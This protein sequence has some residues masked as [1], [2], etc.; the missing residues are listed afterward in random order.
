[1]IARSQQLAGAG[2][3]HHS[4]CVGWDCQATTNMAPRGPGGGGDG[5][6]DDSSVADV[7]KWLRAQGFSE[8]VRDILCDF[9]GKRLLAL[10]LKTFKETLGKLD[11][12]S[13][14]HLLHSGV[15]APVWVDSA[16]CHGCGAPFSF[17]RRKHHCRNCG[18]IVCNTCSSKRLPLPELGIK[19]KVRVCGKCHDLLV[20]GKPIKTEDSSDDEADSLPPD[21]EDLRLAIALLDQDIAAATSTPSGQWDPSMVQGRDPFRLKS[22]SRRF[23]WSVD[24]PRALLA[25]GNR[26][27]FQAPTAV[28]ESA[29]AA[30]ADDGGDEAIYVDVSTL[31]PQDEENIYL[32]VLPKTAVVGATECSHKALPVT[33]SFAHQCTQEIWTGEPC[34]LPDSADHTLTLSAEELG[35]ANQAWTMFFEAFEPYADAMDGERLGGILLTVLSLE[36]WSEDQVALITALCN[37]FV[38][39]AGV[40][41]KNGGDTPRPKLFP[42]ATPTDDGTSVDIPFHTHNAD[43]CAVAPVIVDT[44][45]DGRGLVGFADEVLC[46]CDEA[47]NL[48]TTSLSEEQI[49]ERLD[50][51][52]R[53]AGVA[54]S[55]HPLVFTIALRSSVS[56]EEVLERAI[57][58]A[59][60]A[61]EHFAVPKLS[62]PLQV[63]MGLNAADEVEKGTGV[64]VWFLDDQKVRITPMVC[65]QLIMDSVDGAGSFSAPVRIDKAPEL[66]AQ[67]VTRINKACGSVM[68]Q[69]VTLPDALLKGVCLRGPTATKDAALSFQS[70]LAKQLPK[71]LRS[72]V[73]VH[74]QDPK[75]TFAGASALTRLAS[76]DTMTVS[77]RDYLQFGS[78][79]IHSALSLTPMPVEGET[80]R[81]ISMCAVD[82]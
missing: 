34:P 42:E 64:D 8:T 11:G 44:G 77:R 76:F 53:E 71:A 58:I 31:I 18:Q 15:K 78:S 61:F 29:S 33:D 27:S 51:L 13:C 82:G 47:E 40:W 67:F 63:A 79:V 3:E 65:G 52:C 59:T 9:N 50:R 30:G 25:A 43:A 37:R 62:F 74:I 21:E 39:K 66:C 81:L 6:T 45:A 75:C 10:S 60:V 69:W 57:T 19:S 23:D 20:K 55:R 41:T 16:E 56:F 24:Q 26:R 36:R 22:S 7:Q 5:I 2:H 17:T 80:L 38:A 14:Y 28:P 35:T 32:Q 12:D 54:P 1:M 4:D 68:A 49:T 70:K 46:D 72:A 48:F 73:K